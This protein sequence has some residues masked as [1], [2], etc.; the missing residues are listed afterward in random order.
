MKLE[1]EEECA[2]F[3]WKNFVSGSQEMRRI[4][5]IVWKKSWNQITKK[6]ARA[7]TKKFRFRSSMNTQDFGN[8]LKNLVKPDY[9]EEGARFYQEIQINSFSYDFVR[10][11]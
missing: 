8:Y 9:E 6:N 10:F 7:F 4:F 3:F 11:L 5:E 1:C 2:R